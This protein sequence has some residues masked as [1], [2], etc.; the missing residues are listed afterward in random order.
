MKNLFSV[1]ETVIIQS[2]YYPSYNGKEDTVIEVIDRGFKT[3]PQ[4]WTDP[5]TG[6]RVVIMTRYGYILQ[7]SR[8]RKGN[9]NPLKIVDVWGEN[10]LRKKYSPS[11]DTFNSMMDKI[12]NPS[13][14][15]NA[16]SN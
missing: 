9:R 13:K 7:N 16:L 1:G 14:L 15:P 12:K 5:V 11:D 2:E 10:A 4:P 3:F 6:T 8:R